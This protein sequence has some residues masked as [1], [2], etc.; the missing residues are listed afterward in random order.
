MITINLSYLTRPYWPTCPYP[1]CPRED[2]LR[3][4]SNTWSKRVL[5]LGHV[6]NACPTLFCNVSRFYD[7][8]P[9]KSDEIRGFFAV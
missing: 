4:V 3:Y 7:T 5:S 1:R 8:C 9:V 6:V 2:T